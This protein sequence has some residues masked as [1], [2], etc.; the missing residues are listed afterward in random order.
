MRTS[1]LVTAI[2]LG[3]ATMAGTP[4]TTSRLEGRSSAPTG[5][6]ENKGQVR[7]T[8]GEAAPFVRFHLAQ[9]NTHLFLL[10]NGI[11]YQFNR[12]HYP[13][14]YQEAQAAG[15]T[16]E[17]QEQL[18]ALRSQIRL[19]TFRMDMRLE[20]ADP[21]ARITTEGRSTDYTQYY[22]HE[23][24]G[25]H[26][27]TKVIY[28]DV[29]PGI[30]WVVYTTDARHSG[31]PSGVK[32]D[33]VVSPGA[34]P[35][36]IRLRFEHHEELEV[37]ANGE[38]IHGNR[39]GRFTEERPVSFQGGK[40]IATRFVLED[41]VLR[42]AIEAYDHSRTLT[43]DPAR[44][45]ATYYGGPDNDI[46]RSCTTD[47][48]GDVYLAGYTW[49][50]SAIAAGG[51]QNTL[52][53]G[54]RDAYLVKFNSNGQRLW[55]TYYGGTDYDEGYGSATDAAGNVFLCG[56]TWSS[57]GIG[58]GG[59]QDTYA[60]GQGDAFLV[61]FDPTGAR[62]WA[63]YYGGPGQDRGF[64]CAVDVNGSVYLAGITLSTSGIASGGHQNTMGGSSDAY[65]VKFSSGG[66]REWGTYYGGNNG[67]EGFS[68]TTDGSG[69]VYLAGNTSSTSNIAAG[70]HQSDLAGMLDC[71]LAKFNSAGVRSWATYYGGP[72]PDGEG[73]VA[74]DNA[75]N[76]FL[77]GN[78][79]STSGIASGGH[80]ETYGGGLRD[81]FVA[82]FNGD[83]Q[84]LWGTY[85]GGSDDDL[86]SSCAI[87][88]SGNAY[89]AGRSGSQTGIAAGGFQNIH[90]GLSDAFLVKLNSGG[91][92]LWGTY[93]GGSG[94]DQGYG[95]AVNDDDH[96]FLAGTTP[97]GTG[98]A[99]G[100]HQNTFGGGSGDA[101]LV[102]FEGG[103]EGISTGSIPGPL[104]SETPVS[105]PFTTTGIFNA[106]NTFTAQ[107]SDAS[108][109]FADPVAIGSLSG[110]TSGSI[111]ATIPGGTTTGTG[112]RIRVVSSDPIL[113]GDDNGADVVITAP[114]EPCDDGVS[115][116]LNDVV[117]AECVCAGT[118][119]PIT[120]VGQ[121]NPANA[122]GFCGIAY[123]ADSALVWAYDCSATIIQQY[124]SAGTA[125]RSIPRAGESSNDADLSMAPAQ[126]VLG[127]SMVP[128]GRLLFFNGETGT[129][130]IYGIEQGPGTIIDTLVTAFGLNHVVGGAYHPFRNT[131]FLVQDDDANTV[132]EN[133]VAEVDPATG[134]A[135]NTWQFTGIF[136]VNYG[137]LEISAATGN[138]FL[139]SNS[140]NNVA[141]F[142]PEGALVYMHPLPPGVTALSGLSLD[143]ATGTAWA[144]N[145]SGVI[146]NLGGFPCQLAD[147][148]PGG[149]EPGTPCDDGNAGTVNDEI[150]ADCDCEG[151]L[152][153]GLSGTGTTG[154]DLRVWPNP[155][156]DEVWIDIGEAGSAPAT[157][158][159]RDLLGRT[160]TSLGPINASGPGLYLV[161]LGALAPG[162]YILD[163]GVGQRQWSRRLIKG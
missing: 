62:L 150:N 126:I 53:G 21:Y 61:K 87:D 30:D 122:G 98:M 79:S 23:A 147:L 69:N 60:G 154:T 17:G 112:Y 7:S 107:L 39:M 129:A 125:V 73:R 4:P 106:G 2:T 90:G 72:E 5:F 89:I 26:S 135:L 58:S 111:D 141:E 36:A 128:N 45:W 155:A 22:N 16:A 152:T 137:D 101:F 108:G 65:L 67:A 9:G 10:E 146:Y 28:H 18:D 83:G 52:G 140:Q 20:G 37:N 93:Y 29:Y 12:T 105:V 121:F 44:V 102:K 8:T 120:L 27:Y 127:S 24:L 124:T 77:I 81:G 113:E 96:V 19:E 14:G 97:P 76:V 144:C 31:A 86:A 143:C 151:E 85:Y 49:S 33:F 148:C 109:S 74:T 115:N 88:G 149:P 71:F 34:D 57:N 134:A 66:T 50:L 68:C 95:C 131:Y 94:A 153:T 114:G 54:F 42:F 138:I 48:N 78:T 145:S 117:S 123:D 162:T 163:L 38:L 116:T 159:V 75:G 133:R 15:H 119:T 118:P 46:G 64:S 136:A 103:S 99:D 13:A 132:D 80:Q 63:T 157:L 1:T 156:T 84:R 40:E 51:H 158:V 35:N 70:G 32:Y 47:A 139:V 142:T 41:D 110:T 92:R 82:K 161:Q 160:I 130:D 104:C 25:V 59:H 55:A 11:A 6:E 3:I 56:M 100:G 91:Q 43:I